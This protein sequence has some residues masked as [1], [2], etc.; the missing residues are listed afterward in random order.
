MKTKII[1]TILKNRSL[2]ENDPSN[3]T[4]ICESCNKFN[5]IFGFERYENFINNIL[6]LTE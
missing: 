5:L 3:L 4:H 2:A 6:D 1:K